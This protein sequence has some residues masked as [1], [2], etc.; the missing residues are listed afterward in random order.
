MH[1]PLGLDPNKIH[2][3]AASYALGH[4]KGQYASVL[5]RMFSVV[6]QILQLPLVSLTYGRQRYHW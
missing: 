3:H 2:G 6:L 5:S 4:H 1:L